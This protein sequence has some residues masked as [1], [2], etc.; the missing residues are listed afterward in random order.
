[1]R[2][3]AGQYR[4]KK[5][6]TP[7]GKN[8]RPTSERAREAIFNILNSHLC[9]DYSA[10]H[11]ADIFAGTGAFGLEAL[12]RGAATVTLVDKDTSLA[13][14][15]AKMFV[16]EQEKIRIIK[17]DAL[18]LPCVRTKFN[19]VFMDAPYAKGLTE[20]VLKQL[21][22]KNWL[23]ENSLCIVE[24]R[25]DEHIDIPKEYEILDERV[26]GLARIL[27]LDPKIAK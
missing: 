4:G 1:M 7:D 23:S 3:V 11:L 10:V 12:S 24:I 15:N 25:Q 19:M 13:A 20:E 22:I 18:N 26:Y 17:A 8:V 6:F 5:L 27:F 9:S 14:K 21:I 2:I 16:K